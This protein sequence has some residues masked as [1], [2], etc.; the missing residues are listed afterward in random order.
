MLDYLEVSIIFLLFTRGIYHEENTHVSINKT[1]NIQSN[2]SSNDDIN[3]FNY[4]E[5]QPKVLA[6]KNLPFIN[7]NRKIFC[8]YT[9]F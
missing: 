5:I 4:N 3:D 9:G 2:A 8:S 1:I 7:C 6:N